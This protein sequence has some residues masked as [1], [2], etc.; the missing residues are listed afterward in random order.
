M[1]LWFVLG[2]AA[3]LIKVVPVI[4]GADARGCK[5]RMVATGQSGINLWK[6]FDDFGLPR[7]CAVDLFPREKDLQRSTQALWWFL[8][9]VLR[10]PRAL[11]RSSLP[12]PHRIVV[13]GDT[14]STL[15]GAIWGRRLGWPV[16][17]VEAGL[18]SSRLWQPFPEEINR[19]LVS[20]LATM[21]FAPDETAA[22]N[23][24]GRRGL[25]VNT[26]G[27]TLLDTVRE[28]G[29]AAPPQPGA[30]PLCVANLHRYE[31]LAS[32]SRWVQMIE[33]LIEASRTHRVVFV[34]H[35]QTEHRLNQD[36]QWR[37]RLVQAGVELKPR[38]MFGEFLRLVKQADF[39]IS[40]G[41]SNQEECFYL[42]KPCL[43]LRET[44]E[45]REGLDSTCVLSRFDKKVI[46]DF[47]REPEKFRRPPFAAEV[48]PAR[49]ILDSVFHQIQAG[50]RQIEGQRDFPARQ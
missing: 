11:K 3:E 8:R 46:A 7:E 31:N 41:G 22:A 5:W 27:N 29:N 23:L 43:L 12:G 13:H 19:R 37:E 32:Q 30:R 33:V 47:L 40:D 25:I 10:S 6:Q 26:N 4:R 24:R 38:M 20:R 2:T 15:V 35:P 1:T 48:S 36:W 50:E 42:G 21:H 18:R 9:A 45:R 34:M 49:M 16:A 28:E 14:L 44:T 39:L 17:H